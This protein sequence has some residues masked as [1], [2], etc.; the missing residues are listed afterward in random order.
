VLTASPTIPQSRFYHATRVRHTEETSSQPTFVLFDSLSNTYK[1]LPV[2]DSTQDGMGMAWYTCGPTTYAPAHLGHARTYVWMDILRRV[3]EHTQSH[4]DR[5]APL[6]VMNVT[7][8]DDKILARAIETAESPSSL[9]RRYEEEFWQDLDALGCLRPH[10]V[11]RVTEHVESDIVPY[12]ER[13]VQEEMA[14]VTE[15]G[16]YFD[17]R[18]Y[19]SRMGHV[20]KYGKLAPPSAATDFFSSHDP[21]PNDTVKRDERD[22]ALWKL[23]KEGEDVYWPSPWGEGRPGWHIECSAMIECVQNMFHETHVFQVHAGGVDLKFPHHTNEIAQAEA[24]HPHR[25]AV[26]GEWIPHWIHTGHLHIEGMKMSKSLKNFI[27]IREL[28]LEGARDSAL[29][30]PADDFRLWCLGLSGSYRGPATY[31]PGRI[32]EARTIREK[33]VRFLVDGQDWLKKSGES[34]VKKWGVNEV[35]LYNGVMEATEGCYDAFMGCQELKYFDLDGSTFLESLVEL[36]E[37][38]RAYMTKVAPCEGPTEPLYTALK[39]LR[40]KLSLVG[41]SDATVSAGL[42][43]AETSMS[44]SNIVGGERALAEQL[45]QFRAAVRRNALKDIRE[46]TATSSTN[47]ILRLCDEARDDVLPSIGLELN[48]DKIDDDTGDDEASWR[49]C[50]PREKTTTDMKGEEIP[51][52]PVIPANTPVQDLFRVG[53]YSGLF[54]LFDNDGVPTH[55]SDGS[56]VSK[57]QRKKLVKKREKYIK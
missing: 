4:T 51:S 45:V 53:P 36:S 17:V 47:E 32:D 1:R 54:S 49:F 52:R 13:L 33:L 25:V 21:S 40:D 48:D 55:H 56:E 39:L 12:I 57:S 10:V 26:E 16:V 22:F 46:G 35:E 31:S 2:F 50:L 15:E 37:L 14:Y 23:R 44:K 7:D 11:T 20:T 5:P 30:S 3:L 28:L 42:Y 9:A 6:F 19:D 41:F 29:S 38:G 8:V 24:Y 34:R 27:T 18:E 43:G